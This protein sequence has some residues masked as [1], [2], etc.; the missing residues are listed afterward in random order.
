VAEPRGAPSNPPPVVPG[1][2]SC[3][4][5]LVCAA[6]S[7][8][9]IGRVPAAGR[10]TLGLVHASAFWCVVDAQGCAS[11][12]ASVVL[13]GAVLLPAVCWPPRAGG[14]LSALAAVVCLLFT[15][16][17]A[18]CGLFFAVVGVHWLADGSHGS[19]LFPTMGAA[20]DACGVPSLATSCD[21]R[22][23]IM[24]VSSMAMQLAAMD[25]ISSHPGVP[26]LGCG[27]FLPPCKSPAANITPTPWSWSRP[28]VVSW[29]NLGFCSSL[30]ATGGRCGLGYVVPFGYDY[31]LSHAV[32][33]RA[34]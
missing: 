27:C 31:G 4:A 10:S 16:L 25:V 2:V 24:L 32:R 11:S 34:L 13:D 5:R 21:E 20:V 15:R 14:V 33:A 17:S 8:S 1:L 6:V 19:G 26:W 9:K 12:L 7:L 3:V 30:A 28:C 22:C 18:R 29:Y 23:F